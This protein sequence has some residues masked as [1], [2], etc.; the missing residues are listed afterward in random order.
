MWN[1]G[2]KDIKVFGTEMPAEYLLIGFVVIIILGLI[3]QIRNR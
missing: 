2:V 3:I 1:G